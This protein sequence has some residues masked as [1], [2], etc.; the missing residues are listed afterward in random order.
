[1]PRPWAVCK[2]FSPMARVSE[3][4]PHRAPDD[5]Q[6]HALLGRIAVVDGVVDGLP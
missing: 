3:H 6:G 5:S 1:M 2:Y 4:S